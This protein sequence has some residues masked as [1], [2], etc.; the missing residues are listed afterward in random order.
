MSCLMGKRHFGF[1]SCTLTRTHLGD[2]DVTATNQYFHYLL[3]ICLNIW[4]IMQCMKCLPNWCI[5]LLISFLN[6]ITKRFQKSNM[7]NTSPRF[8]LSFID[9]LDFPFLVD[10]HWS[11]DQWS[12]LSFLPYY[13]MHY[14]INT[15]IYT[16]R[17]LHT[18]INTPSHMNTTAAFT[19]S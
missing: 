11:T 15:H 5:K 8:K 18:P 1:V 6:A 2:R 7:M 17:F 4:L 10:F 9:C 16:C 12:N 3:N 13:Y 14:R 19:T